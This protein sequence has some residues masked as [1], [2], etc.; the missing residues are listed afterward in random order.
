[1]ITARQVFVGWMDQ[2]T[3][4]LEAT[5]LPSEVLGDPQELP[6]SRAKPG[7]VSER[8]AL[9]VSFA[10]RHVMTSLSDLAVHPIHKLIISMQAEVNYY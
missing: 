4:Q 2:Q 3:K 8:L 10:A 6:R 9:I 5:R 1:M 7:C